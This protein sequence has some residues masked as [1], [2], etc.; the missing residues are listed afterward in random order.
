VKLPGASDQHYIDCG[1][2]SVG[3]E[4]FRLLG[5]PLVAGREFDPTDKENSPRV[6]ILNETL[7]RAV[8][9]SANPL[10]RTLIVGPQATMQVVGV[11]KDSKYAEI[12]EKHQPFAFVPYDQAGEE[13]TRQCTFFVRAAAAQPGVMAA[14]RSVV[15]Q[16][17]ANVPIDRL[18]SM[19][20]LIS[21]SLL[22]DRLTAALA[23]AFAILAS[24]LVAVGLY[25]TIS[26]SVARR[27]REFG[28][29]LALGAAPKSLLTFVMRE[30]GWL[31]MIGIAI[32][33]PVS[34]A[35][36]KV[37]ESQLYGVRAYDPVVIASAAL[38]I[39]AVAFV[40][41]LAPAL[42]AMRIEPVR[43]LRYE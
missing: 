27:T 12:R 28:I 5:I 11:V 37:V 14:I 36:A 31:A 25:G 16:A 6:V 32:G 19:E 33:A 4:Y 21:N 38:L 3:A 18:T 7:A 39:A 24:I 17:D 29:R 13:F 2:N 15:K 22:T 40:A 43:A 30:V 9:G 10:G 1:M 23:M 26:Y 20:W 34:Y 8:F 42:R 41:G 35:L